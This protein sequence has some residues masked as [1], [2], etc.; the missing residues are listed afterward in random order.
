MVGDRSF[1]VYTADEFKKIDLSAKVVTGLTFL[2]ENHRNKVFVDK[3]FLKA[4]A[5]GIAKVIG[6]KESSDPFDEA[7]V[8]FMKGD[9]QRFLIKSKNYRSIFS[10]D[11]YDLRV[12]NDDIDGQRSAAFPTLLD[13]VCNEVRN[14][15]I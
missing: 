1:K 15:Q 8:G 13:K 9:N 12:N 4:L 3:I 10:L 2:N 14:N 11:I 7:D 5:I 6:I